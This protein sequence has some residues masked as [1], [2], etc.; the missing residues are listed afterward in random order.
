MSNAVPWSETSHWLY[1]LL[2]F[3][4]I[5]LLVLLIV[6]NMRKAFGRVPPF[7]EEL[8]KR[9][10]AIRKQIYAVENNLR[11][12][13]MSLHEDQ[14]RRIAMLEE[15]YAEMQRDRIRKWDELRTGLGDLGAAVAFIRGKLEGEEEKS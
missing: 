2:G 11:R 13:F 15:Q 5:V 3:L 9:D 4:G 10:K 6:V 12:Q 14:V 1:G 8:D 7:H